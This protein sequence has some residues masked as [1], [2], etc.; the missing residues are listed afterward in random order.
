MDTHL[1]SQSISVFPRNEF[2]HLLYFLWTIRTYFPQFR[3]LSSYGDDSTHHADLQ[4]SMLSFNF[5]LDSDRGT[6]GT[7][8]MRDFKK[9]F[10]C[11]ANLVQFKALT[12]LS[13]YIRTLSTFLCGA[14]HICEAVSLP[15]MLH[16]MIPV[17]RKQAYRWSN[18]YN[19]SLLLTDC[20]AV[21]D[22]PL[23][24]SIFPWFL[25]PEI[26]VLNSSSGSLWLT[27]V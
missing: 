20:R 7:D 27:S 26:S 11:D 1:S 5:D 15:K 16:P 22:L 24:V 19:K 13:P 21:G 18:A 12:T 10:N 8:L 25:F 23:F 3:T 2:L 4:L 14:N 6:I 9:V 17:R